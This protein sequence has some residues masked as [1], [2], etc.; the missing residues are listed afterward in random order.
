MKE[1]IIDKVLC[2]SGYLP[3]RNED[4][5]IAFEKEFTNVKV[6][7]DFHVDVDSIVNGGCRVK[8]MM[9]NIGGGTTAASDMRIAAR[10]FESMPEDVVE[11][12]KK[13][14][15]GKDDKG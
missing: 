6:D 1:S 11:K 3:P 9:R 15:K 14:H 4:E 10:N 13:Q 2:S 7:E 12:I 5:M 8:S